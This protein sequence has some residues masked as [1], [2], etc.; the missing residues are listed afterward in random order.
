MRTTLIASAALAAFAILRAFPDGIRRVFV[1]AIVG[2]AAEHSTAV[3][4]A[5]KTKMDLEAERIKRS[6]S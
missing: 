1:V 6:A 2:N 5:M 4:V 3:L